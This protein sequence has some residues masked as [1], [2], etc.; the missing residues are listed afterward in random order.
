M[1]DN[2]SNR[3]E[4]QLHRI[5]CFIGGYVCA[6]AV[7]IR[8]DVL[9]S[10][11]TSNMIEIIFGLIGRNYTDVMIRAGAFVLY[12]TAILLA[13]VL[14]KK[15][16]VN[17]AVYAVIVQLFCLSILIFIPKEVD[18]VLALYPMFF[19]TATQWSIFNGT[20]RYS[21]STIFSTNNLKQMLQGFGE[22]FLLKDRE[23]LQRGRFYG[24]SVLFFYAGAALSYSICRL[25]FV[26]AIGACYLPVLLALFLIIRNEAGKKVLQGAVPK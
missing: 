24:S 3:T 13:L 19:M 6:Y 25:I 8:A 2:N 1:N 5:M 18:P 11:Q 9:G 14:T 20:G 7:F 4:I 15:T 22:Y 21:C 16:K 17:G 10:A 26:Q 23:A 12:C